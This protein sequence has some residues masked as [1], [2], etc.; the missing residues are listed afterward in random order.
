[1]RLRGR[2]FNVIWMGAALAG[3]V[4]A[5]IAGPFGERIGVLNLL[6]IQGAGYVVAGVAAGVL[7]R[8]VTAQLD[9]GAEPE[10]IG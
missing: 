8:R 7:L 1:D 4:G 3:I 6:T 9:V 2:A 5:A 10:P